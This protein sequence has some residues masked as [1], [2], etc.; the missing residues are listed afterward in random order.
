MV[1]AL[2]T[3]TEVTWAPNIVLWSGASCRSRTHRRMAGGNQVSAVVLAN[4][5]SKMGMDAV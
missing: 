2:S 5:P 3:Q 1:I 4:G